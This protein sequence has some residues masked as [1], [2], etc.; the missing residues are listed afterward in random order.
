MRKTSLTL[1]I[2]TTIFL[3]MSSSVMSQEIVTPKEIIS[4]VREAATFLSEKGEAGLAEFKNPNGPWVLKDSYI[5]VWNCKEGV[6]I[7]HPDNKLIGFQL[8]KMFDK[9]GK[10]LGPALCGAASEPNGSWAEYWWPELG[11]D[12]PER[13]ISYMYTVPGQPYVV[14]AGIYEPSMSL[15]DLNKMVK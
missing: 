1:I 6:V 13:K 10:A 4:K 14:G 5:F 12:V 15:E 8:D 7:A 2:V 3:A 9:N 11:S